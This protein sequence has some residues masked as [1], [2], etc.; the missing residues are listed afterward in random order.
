MSDAALISF[1]EHGHTIYWYPQGDTTS[2]THGYDTPERF[3][4]E[5]REGK[6]GDDILDGAI[7]VDTRGVPNI[8]SAVLNAPLCEPGAQERIKLPP[9]SEWTLA[10]LKGSFRTL[11]AKHNAEPEWSGLDRV[12]PAEF[13]AYWASK[14]AKV[15]LWMCGEVQWEED[16]DA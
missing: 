12:P 5:V 4:E 9:V 11:A 10:G 2:R 15:G 3:T 1:G 14:G 7:V 13:A 16:E 6:Y 8:V